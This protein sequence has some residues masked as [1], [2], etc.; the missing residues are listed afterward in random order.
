MRCWKVL[1]KHFTQ[2]ILKDHANLFILTEF[3]EIGKTVPEKGAFLRT[4][5]DTGHNEWNKTC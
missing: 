1:G 3:V 5:Q 2:N 4:G